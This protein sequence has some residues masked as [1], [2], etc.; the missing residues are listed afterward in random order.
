MEMLRTSEF[1]LA[2]NFKNVAYVEYW[3]KTKQLHVYFCCTDVGSNKEDISSWGLVS[4]TIDNI[5]PKD[6]LAVVAK[7]DAMGG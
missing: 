5:E 2:V 1:G 4:K 7:I 3:R 6:Y